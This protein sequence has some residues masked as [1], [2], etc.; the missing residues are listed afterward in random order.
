MTWVVVISQGSFPAKY[1]QI[2][3]KLPSSV[4][5]GT[6]TSDAKV[7]SSKH[8]TTEPMFHTIGTRQWKQCLSL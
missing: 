4:M 2:S 5:T 6:Q 8:Y 7:A 1:G 3:L